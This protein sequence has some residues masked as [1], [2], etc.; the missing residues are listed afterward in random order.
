MTCGARTRAGTPCKMTAIHRNGR[1]KLHGGMSTGP[2][3][4][5]GKARSAANGLAPKRKRTP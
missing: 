3:S 5:A 1:C 2:R 4:N